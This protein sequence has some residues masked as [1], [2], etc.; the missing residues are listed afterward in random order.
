MGPNGAG[1][2]TLLRIMLGQVLPTTGVVRA[3]HERIGSIAQ[4]ASDWMLEESLLGELK[5]LTARPDRTASELLS[6]RFPLALAERPLWSLSPGERVRAALVCLFQRSPPVE[7]LVLDEP[8]HGLD[9]LGE[10]A[11]RRTLASWPGGLVVVSHEQEFV[12]AIGAHEVV[13]LNTKELK[14][15]ELELS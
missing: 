1:K 5:R 2:T 15:S 9:F 4:G 13:R 7:M 10:A 8:T 14:R 11:L 12:D 6:H 3:R